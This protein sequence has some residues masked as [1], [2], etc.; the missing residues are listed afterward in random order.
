MQCTEIIIDVSYFR[1]N[2]PLCP[3][4]VLSL[5]VSSPHAAVVIADAD[6]VVDSLAVVRVDHIRGHVQVL[7]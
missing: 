3:D 7:K 5:T 2:I 4:I 6:E 1:Q